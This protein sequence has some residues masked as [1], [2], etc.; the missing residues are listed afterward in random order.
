M[1]RRRLLAEALGTCLLLAVVIGSRIMAQRL[2]EGNNGLAL[3]A[4]AL[5]TVGGLYMLIETL[6][7][8]SGAHF[9]P[10]VISPQCVQ[11]FVLAKTA[12]AIAGLG[13]CRRLGRSET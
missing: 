11:P 5:A 7:P 13:I 8:V 3:L 1:I 12:G 6:G 10:A 4:N 2:C 9:N